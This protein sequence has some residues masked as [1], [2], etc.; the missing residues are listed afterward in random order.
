MGCTSSA[1][2][3]DEKERSYA[4]DKQIEEDKKKS[5][6]ECK[7][8]LLGTFTTY[9]SHALCVGRVHSGKLPWACSRAVSGGL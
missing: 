5:S 4:I 1:P 8:L 7:I 9:R 2:V 3:Q 6:R